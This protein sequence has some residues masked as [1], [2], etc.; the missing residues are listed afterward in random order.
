M[1]PADP[2][3]PAQK[4]VIGPEKHLHP[5]H[6][7]PQG[8]AEGLQVL[9][10]L[11]G[12]PSQS[13]LRD[14]RFPLLS[15]TVTSSPGRGKSFLKVGALG[16]SRRLHLF[17]KA[18]PFGRGGTAIAVTERARMLPGT[19]LFHPLAPCTKTCRG[20]LCTSTIKIE[21]I[22]KLL[23]IMHQKRQFMKKLKIFV[24]LLIS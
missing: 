21:T 24:A 19:L 18:S 13:S 22:L 23:Q 5:S 6:P 17:A 3:P 15:P 9:L 1:H 16:S 4:Q 10:F 8:P 12:S 7:R 20:Y 11:A 14:A 2:V